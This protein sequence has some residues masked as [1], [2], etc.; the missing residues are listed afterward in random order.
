MDYLMDWLGMVIELMMVFVS[1]EF[2][3]MLVYLWEEITDNVH[4]DEEITT[5]LFVDVVCIFFVEL[6]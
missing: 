4:R 3:V 5:T 6:F 1:S 2:G